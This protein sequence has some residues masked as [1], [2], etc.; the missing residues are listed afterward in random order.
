M[1]ATDLAMSILPLEVCFDLLKNAVV[2]DLKP[3][4]FGLRYG[5]Y[6]NSLVSSGINLLNG[7]F[8]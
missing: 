5:E 8:S 4:L 3:S 6:S 7:L 2:G 1:Y